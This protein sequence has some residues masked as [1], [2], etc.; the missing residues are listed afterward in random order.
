MASEPSNAMAGGVFLAAGVLGGVAIGSINGQP[1]IGFLVG[2][3]VG[4]ALA[5]TVWW[6]N[7]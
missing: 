2:L 1:S 7:R 5:A 4:V 3:G 6:R